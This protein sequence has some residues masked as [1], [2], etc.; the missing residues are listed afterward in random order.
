[1]ILPRRIVEDQRRAQ[2]I[3]DEREAE[4]EAR[5]EAHRKR[6]EA[7]RVAEEQLEKPPQLKDVAGYADVK[8]RVEELIIWPDKHSRAIRRPSRTSG[9]LFFGP[10]GCGKSRLAR[11]IAGELGLDVRL[12]SP[13]DL[14]GT[15]VGWGQILIR[16]QFDWV[17]EASRPKLAECPDCGAMVSVRAHACPKCGCP[18]AN[19]RGHGPRQRISRDRELETAILRT[20]D[21]T[22]AAV[23]TFILYL[24]FWLPGFIV[25]LVYMEKASR[26]K[27]ITGRQ[28]AGAGCLIVLLCLFVIAPL[29]IIISIFAV[30]ALR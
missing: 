13:S 25:N 14:R 6:V 27:I 2:E 22:S 28:P 10:P 26:I 30:S 19:E 8:D 23:L 4:E 29:I 24:F 18:F 12:L 17:A 20:Q 7:R 9:I 11:A 21:L 5:E 1:M 15:Y 16:E 3:R